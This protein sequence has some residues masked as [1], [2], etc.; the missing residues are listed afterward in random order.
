MSDERIEDLQR[1]LRE[2]LKSDLS[3]LKLGQAAIMA[4]LEVMNDKC[5]KKEV[6]DELHIRISALESSQSRII[7]GLVV[8]QIIGGFVLAVILKFW[9]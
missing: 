4:R 7:G 8:F 3:E 6:T 5:A 9:K 2:R 1:E